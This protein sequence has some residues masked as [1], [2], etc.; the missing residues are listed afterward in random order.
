MAQSNDTPFKVE[1]A[2]VG[3]NVTE[4]HVTT[5]VVITDPTSDL[6][7]Q[8]PEGS[9]ASTVGGKP[10]VAGL[11]EAQPVEDVFDAGEASEVPSSDNSVKDED[12]A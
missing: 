3:E 12:E 8:I 6:A 10:A 4:T 9:G 11:A 2:D 1:T 5:D 7:V